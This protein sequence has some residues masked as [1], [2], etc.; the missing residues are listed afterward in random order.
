MSATDTKLRDQ[1]AAE[2]AGYQRR[3]TDERDEIKGRIDWLHSFIQ[4]ASFDSVNPGEQGMLKEQ[5]KHMQEYLR[6]LNQRVKFHK[7]N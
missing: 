4:G 5:F 1:L 6:V 3:V 7:E 2:R